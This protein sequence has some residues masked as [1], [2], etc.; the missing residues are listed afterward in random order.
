MF[1]EKYESRIKQMDNVSF[2]ILTGLRKG[3]DLVF[4]II[5]DVF[6]KGEGKTASVLAVEVLS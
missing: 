1:A 2:S 5:I 6:Q 3:I 4:G